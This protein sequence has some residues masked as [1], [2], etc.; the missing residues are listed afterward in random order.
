MAES[1]CVVADDG[2]L[3]SPAATGVIAQGSVGVASAPDQA[4]V[5]TAATAIGAVADKGE[6]EGEGEGGEDCV[7]AIAC[8]SKVKST[9]QQRA[10]ESTVGIRFEAG[11]VSPSAQVMV[12]LGL[13][14]AATKNDNGDDDSDVR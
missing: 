8:K 11:D 9:T 10:Y 14:F 1:G 6:S 13:I 7:G 3:P 5:W 12:C 2:E 4:A